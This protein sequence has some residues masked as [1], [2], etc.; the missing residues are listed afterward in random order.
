VQALAAARQAFTF[1]IGDGWWVDVDDAPALSGPSGSCRTSL[2]TSREI[3]LAWLAE[4][5][6][7]K[8]SSKGNEPWRPLKS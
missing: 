5:S 1:D 6:K 3:A 4:G 2:R 7:T 8:A